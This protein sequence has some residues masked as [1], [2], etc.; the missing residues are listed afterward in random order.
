MDDGVL[1]SD[2]LKGTL[3][4]IYILSCITAAVL[5]ILAFCSL[6]ATEYGLNYSWISKTVYLYLFM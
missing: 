1:T 4:C 2:V 3:C 5:L 6:E